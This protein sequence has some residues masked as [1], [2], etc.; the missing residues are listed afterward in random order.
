MSTFVKDWNLCENPNL[1][2]NK[3]WLNLKRLIHALCSNGSLPQVD[4]LQ[5]YHHSIQLAI[6]CTEHVSPI[7]HHLHISLN[8][9]L[10]LVNLFPL[11]IQLLPYI[12][13]LVGGLNFCLFTS[14]IKVKLDLIQ[15]L[16]VTHYN[17]W[18]WSLW[19]AWSPLDPP[20]F[21]NCKNDHESKFDHTTG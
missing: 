8:S 18:H 11:M 19:M 15:G 7:C 4:L 16:F 3:N 10:K 5:L 12:S 14:F 17:E 13:E 6:F 20:F 9:A 1:F 2:L 21:T